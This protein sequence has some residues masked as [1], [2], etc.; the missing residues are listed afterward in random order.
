MAKIIKNKQPKIE[1]LDVLSNVKKL[2]LYRLE[3]KK[4]AKIKITICIKLLT[5]L[6]KNSIMK[7]RF[8]AIMIP[9]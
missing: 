8:S 6:L 3:Y 5:L 4:E 1:I 7:F 9:K 2:K